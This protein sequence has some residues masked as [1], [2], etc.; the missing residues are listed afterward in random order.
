MGTDI[1]R[2]TKTV[3]VVNESAALVQELSQEVRTISHLL[4]PPLLDD[5]GL[6]SALR[7]YVEG[8][9]QR[10]RRFSVPCRSVSP[11]FIAIQKAR[12]RGFAFPLLTVTFA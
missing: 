9:A 6:A 7:W 11:I 4:H 10:K 5:A 12:L 3:N 8:F 1:E 2:L